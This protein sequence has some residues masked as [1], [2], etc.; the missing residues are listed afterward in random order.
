MLVLTGRIL[1]RTYRAGE[2]TSKMVKTLRLYGR[3]SMK[4]PAIELHGTPKRRPSRPSGT[5]KVELLG[6]MEVKC[7]TGG[8]L[9]FNGAH[10]MTR[11]KPLP[12]LSK[13]RPP[14]PSS[15]TS[16]SA[17]VSTLASQS[18]L[19]PSSHAS[20]WPSART[21]LTTSSV[22]E[23]ASQSIIQTLLFSSERLAAI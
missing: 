20:L 23:N 9:A 15:L 18:P 6:P 13:R 19:R 22:L 11:F 4:S 21:S 10:L 3:Q 1:R 7:G 14:P 2:G 17:L 12:S 8:N 16:V 5:P